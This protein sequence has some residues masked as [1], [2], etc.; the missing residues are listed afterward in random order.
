MKT[1][2]KTGQELALKSKEIRKDIIRSI[3]EAGSGHTGGSLDLADIFTCLYFNFLI[4]GLKIQNGRK[5]QADIINRSCC[6]STLYYLA[7]AGYFQ[8]KS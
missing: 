8:L 5:R 3:T 6:T 4:I 7:H 2:L 1:I